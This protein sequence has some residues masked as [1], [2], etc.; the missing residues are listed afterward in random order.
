MTVHMM[1]CPRCS[2]YSPA[3]A[4][5]CINC[6]VPLSMAATSTTQLLS[7]RSTAMVSLPARIDRIGLKQAIAGG[8][9]L[10]PLLVLLLLGYRKDG[11]IGRD[12]MAVLLLLMG[13]VQLARFTCQGRFTIGLRVGVLCLALV[14]I[15]E[16]PWMLTPCAITAA[17]LA[18]LYVREVLIRMLHPHLP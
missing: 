18:A 6:S 10:A 5:F 11:N 1:V 2:G 13:F 7:L 14:V 16:T 15:S 17:T 8:I 3:D 9:V 12:F 4:C